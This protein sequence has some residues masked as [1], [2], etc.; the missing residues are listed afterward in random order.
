MKITTIE[1]MN[2]FALSLS[3]KSELPEN[4]KIW[5]DLTMK[6]FIDFQ[7]ELVK[8]ILPNGKLDL[9]VY[10]DKFARYTYQ[11]MNVKFLITTTI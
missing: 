3:H 5:V 2:Y 9:S 7:Q 10:Q 4:T 11:Y 1:Q 6:E 8:T